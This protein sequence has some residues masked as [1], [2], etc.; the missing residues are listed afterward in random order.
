[1]IS[2][3]AGDVDIGALIRRAKQGG[4]GAIVVFDGIVRDDGI[5]E[6]ELEAYR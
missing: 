5:A 4:T 1:M 2:I 6:M 3:Q